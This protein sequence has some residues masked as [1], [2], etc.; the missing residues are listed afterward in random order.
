MRAA[1]LCLGLLSTP[2]IAAACEFVDNRPL[3]IVANPADDTPPS[4][5]ELSLP[6]VQRGNDYG[7]DQGC[8]NSTS[9]DGTGYIGLRV[10]SSDDVSSPDAIGYRIEAPQLAHSG[11]VL[12]ANGGTLTLILRGTDDGTDDLRFT[13]RIAAVD[14]AGNVSEERTVDVRSQGDGCQL[15]RG[16]SGL[17]ALLL[18]LTLV[19][20][21][22]LSRRTRGAATS[23]S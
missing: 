11:Q 22:A 4:P 10:S 7:G 15:A 2:S 8:N 3:D 6:T 1:L 17:G 5:P 20:R 21:S 18:A 16:T 9:C 14:G 19:M 13:I 23:R 12:V